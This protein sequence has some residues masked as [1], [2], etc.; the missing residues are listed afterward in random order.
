MLAFFVMIVATIQDSFSQTKPHIF[1][2]PK[3]QYSPNT[4]SGCLKFSFSV[5]GLLNLNCL[6]EG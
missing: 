6:Q 2:I 1:E 4:S 5:E 3:N